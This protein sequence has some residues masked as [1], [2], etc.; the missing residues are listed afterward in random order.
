MSCFARA[1]QEGTTILRLG[2]R[3]LRP[4]HRSRS[5]VDPSWYSDRFPPYRD[6]RRDRRNRLVLALRM[7]DDEVVLTLAVVIVVFLCRSV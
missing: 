5:L 2:P 4:R 7:P 1:R 6:P 3:L